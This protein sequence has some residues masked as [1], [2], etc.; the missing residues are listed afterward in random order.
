[1]EIQ[2]LIDAIGTKYAGASEKFAKSYDGITDKLVEQWPD[3]KK[4][5]ADAGWF[6]FVKAQAQGLLDLVEGWWKSGTLD[7]LASRFSETFAAIGESMLRCGRLALRI[8]RWSGRQFARL[9]GL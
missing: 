1:K 7:K 2:L 6:E 8:G 9:G 5:V 4:A 3:F